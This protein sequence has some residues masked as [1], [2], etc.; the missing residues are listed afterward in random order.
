M[1]CIKA[2]TSGFFEVVSYLACHATYKKCL[3]WLATATILLFC[4]PYLTPVR[5]STDLQPYAL[6]PAIGVVV[7]AGIRPYAKLRIT[8]PLALLFIPAVYSLLISAAHSGFE[9]RSIAGY[10]F[11]AIYAWSGYVL[12]KEHLT[13]P[14]F[15]AWA[16]ALWGVAGVSETFIS[17]GIF[18]FILPRFSTS[19]ERGVVG[20]ASEPSNYASTLIMLF[21]LIRLL[22]I[23]GLVSRKFHWWCCLAIIVQVVFIARSSVGAL[24]MIVYAMLCV[25]LQ[26]SIK[27]ILVSF[28]LILSVYWTLTSLSSSISDVRIVAITTQVMENPRLLLVSDASINER[29]S[30]VVVSLYGF[31][32]SLPF[33]FGYG[34][35]AW[36][37]FLP[38]ALQGNFPMLSDSDQG[39]RIMS[40]YGGALF[41]L[42]YIGLVI[43][44]V[45]IF[46][47]VRQKENGITILGIF[48]AICMIH[49]VPI[50][51]P[52]FGFILGTSEYL[53]RSQLQR[54]GTQHIR[55]LNGHRLKANGLECD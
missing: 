4:F 27:K 28:V 36:G 32:I 2:K 18:S 34:T 25:I 37:D 5:T 22:Y 51:H 40:A 42:G 41:E 3:K 49:I 10:F 30:H 7:L 6:F 46:S 21:I 45:Q 17:G 8:R 23:K 14:K 55:L 44:A 20:L 29:L 16:I 43:P 26:P 38:H 35:T 9:L 33:A 39:G 24:F 31:C 54:H 47:F 11:V 50:S 19:L 12:Q 15:I 1:H 48:L 53:R 52:L 13:S